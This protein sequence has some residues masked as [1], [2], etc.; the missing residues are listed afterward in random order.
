MAS[1]FHRSWAALPRPVR[2]VLVGGVNTLF[3]YTAYAALVFVGLHFAL[4]AFLGTVAGVLFNFMTTGT[5]VFDGLSR[6]RL[7]RFVA[8]YALTYVLNVALLAVLTAAGIDAYRAGLICI[9]P[10]AGVSYLLMRG[11]VFG[12]RPWR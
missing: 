6:A 9:V 7:V 10:M 11:I 2:F 4:A 3:G 8:V 1:S 12:D 5:L